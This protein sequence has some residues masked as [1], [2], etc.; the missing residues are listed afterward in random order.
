MLCVSS[1]CEALKRNVDIVDL[2]DNYEIRYKKDDYRAK[3][4]YNQ[5]NGKK[6]NGYY[7]GDLIGENYTFISYFKR[8]KP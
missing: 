1:S 8:G 5:L 4:F 2:G 3:V 6:L 7:K